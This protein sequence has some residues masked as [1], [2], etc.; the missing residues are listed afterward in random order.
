M[1]CKNWVLKC[2]FDT[3][4]Q[5]EFACCY[6]AFKKVYLIK[7]SMFT[8]V[9]IIIVKTIIFD[10]IQS[11]MM[12]QMMKTIQEWDCH[13]KRHSEAMKIL[14]ESTL[15]TT[16]KHETDI[17][18]CEYVMRLIW[19]WMNWKQLVSSSIINLEAWYWCFLL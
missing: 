4:L 17:L 16:E 12:M 19:M 10:F 6:K 9:I 3:V 13:W 11:R 8:I 7:N 5:N 18:H 15:W 14:L 1:I 2:C